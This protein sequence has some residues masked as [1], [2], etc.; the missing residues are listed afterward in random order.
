GARAYS[1]SK[2]ALIA[3][4]FELAERLAASGVA[5]V[6]ANALHPAT[7]MPTTMVKQRFGHTQSTLE[8]GVT[9][10]LRLVEGAA[11]DGVSGRYF[12]GL[13]PARAKSQA[14]DVEAR[15]R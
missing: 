4:T 1:R 15:R 10:T 8:E 7:L 14:Y 5:N 2:L 12:D 13:Q 11:L 6:T 9:A 3:F